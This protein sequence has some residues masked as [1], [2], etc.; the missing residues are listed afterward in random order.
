MSMKYYDWT[1]HQAYFQPNKTAIV[2]LYTGRKFTY[3]ALDDRAARLA[4]W[5]Q[6][7]GVVKGD[8]IGILAFNCPEFMEMQFACGKIGAVALPVNWRLTVPELEFIFNDST[9]KVLVHDAHFRDAALELKKRCDISRLLDIDV[10]DP[11]NAYEQA[12]DAS[13]PEPQIEPLTLDDLAMIM[14]TSGTTGHPKG[15]MITHGMNFINCVNLGFIA[16]IS[17]LTVQLVVLPLFHTGGL[18]CYAN[19]VIHAGG[20][21]LLLREFDP[22]ESLRVIG[23]PSYEV[24]HFFAVPAPYQFMMHHPDFEKTDLSRLQ[25]AGVGGAPC[26]ETVLRIWMDRGVDLRPGWGMTETS[27]AGTALDPV[28]GLRKIGS[29]GKAVMHTEIKIVDGVGSEVTDGGVGELMIR[30]PN[31]T[32]GYWNNAESTKS[33]FVDGWLKTGD[34]AR[35]DEEGFIYIVDRWKDMYISGGENVYPA[36]V[37]NVI[38]Q[39]PQV[40]EAAVI[41]VPDDRWGETGKAVIAIKPGET[42][43]EETVISHCVAHLAK[44]KVPRSVA[45]VDELP[46]NATGKVLKRELRTQLLGNDAPAIS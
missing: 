34:A 23:D 36:E 14:Y 12:L 43:D 37:E 19:P 30:G 27:P 28:D 40:L 10:N 8:R 25:V 2:D 41:G 39:L 3:A 15:A 11:S 32:P 17:P 16:Q 24:T 6:K 38:Y 42:L 33:S 46:H 35:V 22:G 20:R 21:I 18:N 31:I 4:D 44:F 9:P 13:Y 29:A 7:R 5:L 26:P 1:A 45:F